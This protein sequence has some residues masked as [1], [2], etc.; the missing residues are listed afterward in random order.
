IALLR[1]WRPSLLAGVLG[2]LASEFWFLGF[3]LASAAS[4]RTLGLVEVL[5]AQLAA[6]LWM[7]QAPSAREIAGIA[8]LV[9]GIVLLVQHGGAGG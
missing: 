2:A 6:S 1:S 3:S 4:V 7:R 8:L 9:V 5:F